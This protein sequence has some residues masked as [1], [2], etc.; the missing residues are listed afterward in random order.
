VLEAEGVTIGAVTGVQGISWHELTVRGQ[1]NHAGTTPMAMRHDAGFV[2]ARIAAYVRELVKSLGGSQVGTV[3]A[4]DLHP[5]LVNVVAS[6]AVMTVDLRNTDEEM[7][8]RAEQMLLEFADEAAREEGVSL[9]VRQLARFEPVQFDERLIDLV[10]HSAR[11][12]G[13]TVRRIASGAGH[14]AQMF[15]RLCPSAMIFVP[16]RDGLS[17]NVAEFTEPADLAAGVD[18]LFDVLVRLAEET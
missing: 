14:D 10:E 6:R 12:S 11:S 8:Q 7:L 4:I 17:H 13:H 3:G 15:A 9:D 1:S 2:A 16:S 5:N 18:V